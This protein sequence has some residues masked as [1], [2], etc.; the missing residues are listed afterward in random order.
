MNT[1]SLSLSPLELDIKKRVLILD[2]AMGT[3]IQPLGL[4]EEQFRGHRFAN[5]PSPLKGCNDILCL[6]LPSAIADIHNSYLEAGADIITTCSFNSNAPSLREY[7]LEQLVPEINRR[8]AEIARQCADNFSTSTR[9]R[10]VAGSMGPTGVSLS[11]SP[12]T[13]TFESLAHTYSLQAE[14]LAEGGADILLIE[15]AF[16]PINA[17][18]AIAGIIDARQRSGIHLPVIVSATLSR[19]GRLLT[20][21][22]LEAFLIAIDHIDPLAVGINCGF[23]V[24]TLLPWL[25]TL[26]ST[27]RYVSMHANAGLPDADGHYSHTPGHMAS[28]LSEAL[29][30]GKLNIVGGCCGTTPVH[31]SKI[32]EI[33]SSATPHI[34][35]HI[36]P[37]LRLSGGEPM[38]SAPIV[39]VGE[40]CNVAGSRKFLRLISENKIGEAVE[41]AAAQVDAG[42]M[43]IDIN[44]D[45]AMINA[46]ERITQFIEALAASPK[47]FR[48]P[49][50]VDSSDFSTIMTA[51]SHIQGKP[52]VN[53]ISLKEGEALFLEHA[54][55]IRRMGA[56]VVV[57]AFDEQG[58]ATTSHRKYEICARAY[59]LLTDN[60]IFPPHDIVFDPAVLTIATGISEH[61]S[62]GAEF[63]E[64]TRLIRQNLPGVGISGGVSNLSFS[65]R[66]NDSLRRDMHSVFISLASRQG[67]DMAI[68]NPSTP[69][70]DSHIPASVRS[71]ISEA[72]ANP[73]PEA[74]NALTDYAATSAEAAAA[75]KSGAKKTAKSTNKIQP[76]ISSAIFSGDADAIIPLVKHAIDSGTDAMTIISDQLMPAMTSVGEE[77]A[78]GR[79]Y[80][81]SVVRAAAV[82][83]AAMSV[84]EPIISSSAASKSP[85]EATSSTPVIIL[86]TV[87]GDV[88]DIGKNIVGAVLR[89]SGFKVVDLGVMVPP[90]DIIEAALSHN[91]S[92]IAL[93]GLITPS[94][95]E[96]ATVAKLMESHSLTIP[97][98]VGGATTSPRHTAVRLAPL[99]PNSIVIHTSDAASLP[100]LLRESIDPSTASDTFRRIRG[101][102]DILIQQHTQ[103]QAKI[104]EAQSIKNDPK[105]RSQVSP[106]IYQPVDPTNPGR[107]DIFIDPATL[108]DLLNL[109]AFLHAWHFHP[110]A[111]I[112]NP[113]AKK[114]ID[115]ALQLIQTLSAK[116]VRLHARVN[117]TPAS[118]APDGI[119]LPNLHSLIPLPT[120]SRGESLVNFIA[121]TNDHVA[122]F[123]VTA[124]SDIASRIESLKTSG[125]D[126]QAL[127][128]QSLADRLVEA[129]TEW[130]HRY[131]ASSL[132]G[133][134]TNHQNIGI[135]PAV[136]YPAIPSLS[137]MPLFGS[138]LDTPSMGI[139]ITENGALYPQATT[140]GIIIA[141]PSATY[142]NATSNLPD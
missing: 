117:I 66:G 13:E 41:I 11:M 112:D 137:L 5:H 65:F 1:S 27:G 48:P 20:G 92:A 31:I 4:T 50:M 127:L 55:A 115:E 51:L 3:M 118:P 138:L 24:D 102:Q 130:T 107:H 77:F 63:L 89:C 70:S 21:Q 121:P 49:V 90:Q 101:Q 67:L 25:D 32:A 23:G 103:A 53:S 57:M 129:A 91:A 39:V 120:N 7:R 132:W 9:R 104:A 81:P 42:A 59:H 114:I 8:A 26:A 15:T 61:D 93:S 124:S 68:L 84:L 60:N 18:A 96:M 125:N 36:P 109:R 46:S 10:Y 19:D 136:G 83:K 47:G 100:A 106:T 128:L 82:M 33:A 52:I 85:Q 72:I 135:R 79:I 64:A 62:Y 44:M 105:S 139:S 98:F 97:L 58:Q 113:E 140:M 56:A 71:I 126:Y 38:P 78:A 40:R 30:K 80:L 86:A 99:R 142:I 54:R 74:T 75:A 28:L 35:V 69:L 37:R 122:L 2:G 12:G 17:K 6:T 16:D 14:A 131:V 108:T 110:T 76:T 87:K 133:Y 43:A 88:H 111:D 73:S 116:G 22:S 134:A 29:T 141:N 119:Y 34:P 45:D 94:L 123:A 95:G